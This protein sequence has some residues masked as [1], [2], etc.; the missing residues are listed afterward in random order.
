MWQA[1]VDWFKSKGGFAHVVALF[2]ASAIA[3]YGMVPAFAQLVN[4]IYST[5]PEWSHQLILAFLG[6]YAW[7]KQTNKP[8]MEVKK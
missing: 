2:F 5:M 7:Y 6:L 1:I 4:N 8:A 3:A